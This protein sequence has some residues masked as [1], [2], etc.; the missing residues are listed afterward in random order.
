MGL[1]IFR[2]KFLTTLNHR[3]KRVFALRFAATFAC[4]R[5]RAPE[6][7]QTGRSR[8]I[9]RIEADCTICMAAT[10]FSTG[11]ERLGKRK[12]RAGAKSVTHGLGNAICRL[13]RRSDSVRFRPHGTASPR[14]PDPTHSPTLDRRR[15]WYRFELPWNTGLPK[16][17]GS[18]PGSL[19]PSKTTLWKFAV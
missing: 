16:I 9:S 8:R 19:P 18:K 5:G 3:T 10:R 12:Q 14:P 6:G 11:I 13:I 15:A 17:Y 7:R 4:V 2:P 1:R